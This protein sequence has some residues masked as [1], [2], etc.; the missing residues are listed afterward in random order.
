[1]CILIFLMGVC[2]KI[3][4]R[5]NF[6]A[7]ILIAGAIVALIFF[8]SFLRTQTQPAQNY[9]LPEAQKVFQAIDRILAET[10][11]RWSGPPREIV[12]TESELNSY[13]AYRIETE[14]EEIMKELKLKLFEMNR[15]EAK[16]HIDLRGQ[17]VPQFIRPELDIYF[18]ADLEVA[19]GKA[20]LN[21]KEI[22][23]GDQPVRPYF[24]DLI[25]A[26]SARINKLEASSITDWYELPYGIK[27]IKTQKGMAIF[28][29]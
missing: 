9:S 3:R 18:A 29:Y 11:Q 19:N 14:K 7:G 21:L 10:Q 8:T 1:M 6:R 25:I 4:V 22:F 27:D 26:I 12:I 24:I 20:K 15:I 28:Y 13:I 17:D 16:I 23:I 2:Q 5:L